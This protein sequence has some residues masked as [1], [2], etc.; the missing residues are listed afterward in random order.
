MSI[1]NAEIYVWDQPEGIDPEPGEEFVAQWR[2]RLDDV[3]GWTDPAFNISSD[4]SWVVPF[5]MGHDFIRD[6]WDLEVGFEPDVFHEFELRSPDMRTYDLYIDGTLVGQSLFRALTG[7]SQV[8]WGPGTQGTASLTRWDYV[9]FGVV[10]EPT[11][12]LALVVLTLLGGDVRRSS[13]R[14]IR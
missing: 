9:R 14:G 4:G 6:G 1:S 5:S 13:L 12:G 8:T 10:P 2:V 3:D 11:A 7:Q